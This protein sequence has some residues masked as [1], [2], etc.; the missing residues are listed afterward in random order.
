MN[1]RPKIFV[2]HSAASD[3]DG[4]S[5]AMAEDGTL[6]GSHY[7][8]NEWH[9]ARDLG[10]RPGTM[11]ERHARYADHYASGYDMVFVPVIQV[12][13]HPGLKAAFARNRELHAKELVRSYRQ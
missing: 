5:Y 1:G 2:W 11:P 12:G 3:G 6:L 8:A 9:A 10:V 7:C 4:L 13:T